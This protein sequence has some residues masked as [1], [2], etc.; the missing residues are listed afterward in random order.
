MFFIGFLIGAMV[1]GILAIV[2]HCLVIVG[3]ESDKF[4]EEE[5][6]TKKEKKQ[7]K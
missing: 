2:L 3:K 7:E 1:G 4:W 6:I 5:K